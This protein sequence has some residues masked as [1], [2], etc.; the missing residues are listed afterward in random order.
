[1]Y[2]KKTHPPIA[3]K[4]FSI[5]IY[6]HAGLV[7]LILTSAL[8]IGIVGY[9]ITAGLTWID[10]LLEASM[11]LGG[12]GPTQVLHTTGAKLFASFYSLFSGLVFIGTAGVMVAPFI[13]RLLHRFHFEE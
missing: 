9:H 11:I 12:M 5:R 1:M 7:C 8:A 2:E 13:H 6:R 10:S 4:E 3:K